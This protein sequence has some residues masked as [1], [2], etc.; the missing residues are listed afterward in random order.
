MKYLLQAMDPAM[1]WVEA[2][3]ACKPNSESWAKFL[4]EEVYS[5]F[6]CVL[7]CLVDGCS[8]FKGT[9]DILFKQYGIVVIVSSP[10]HPEG[11]GHAECLHQMLVNSILRTCG[12][13]TLCWPLYVHAGLWAMQ[14][15]TSQVTGYTPYFLLYGLHPLFA[16]DIADRTWDVLDWHT[17]ASM[18]DLLTMCMQQ[19]LRRDK[20]LVLAM[21][22]QK[23]ACQQVVDNFNSKHKHQLS[24]GEFLLGTWVLLHETWLDSQMGNKGALRWTG[25]YIIHRKLQDTTY[26]L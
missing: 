11:N 23:H 26:Q 10:Y 20:Q 25:P 14:C 9:V 17:V 22:Q 24:S 16:F 15:S 4:C 19:I 8:E 6:G 18:E 12:K 7:L 5:C 2:C 21:E 1:S 3:T 13:D